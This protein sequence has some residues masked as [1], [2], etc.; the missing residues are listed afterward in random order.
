MAVAPRRPLGGEPRFTQALCRARGSFSGAVHARRRGL[1]AGSL[2]FKSAATPSEGTL[3]ERPDQPFGGPSVMVVA[4]KAGRVGAWL[5]G[6]G[7]L[8]RAPGE[9]PRPRRTHRE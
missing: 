9:R 7:A 6:S 3:V 8:R 5:S 2:G 4:R 1:E